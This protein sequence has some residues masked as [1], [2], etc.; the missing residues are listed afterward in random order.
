[1]KRSTFAMVVVCALVTLTS[2][3]TPQLAFSEEK[4]VTVKKDKDLPK[5]GVLASTSLTG[6]ASNRADGP[7]GGEDPSGEVV[8][9]ITG[10]LSRIGKNGWALKVFNNSDKDTYMVEV[11]VIQSDDRE[12]VC[13]RDFFTYTLGPQKSNGQSVAAGM[14]AKAAQLRLSKY[15]NLTESSAKAK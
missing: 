2:V 9:P 12:I 15:R 11:E 7:F 8:S 3:V 10:S 6:R 14:G 1:M 4:K 5:G 13:K